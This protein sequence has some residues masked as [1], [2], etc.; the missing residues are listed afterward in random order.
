MLINKIRL[1]MY[2]SGKHSE[3]LDRHN[4]ENVTFVFHFVLFANSLIVTHNIFMLIIY[5]I[6]FFLLTQTKIRL[7][8]L[9]SRVIR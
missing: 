3:S 1:K 6:S 2:L 8:Q 5:R 9:D 4:T 7:S